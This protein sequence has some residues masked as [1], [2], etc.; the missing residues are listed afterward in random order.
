MKQ[1]SRI[2]IKA[3]MG[4]PPLGGFRRGENVTECYGGRSVPAKMLSNVVLAARA[5]IARMLTNV[6]FCTGPHE[7]TAAFPGS[8]FPSAP[9]ENMPDPGFAL[10]ETL[11]PAMR[12][13]LQPSVIWTEDCPF[14][15]ALRKADRGLSRSLNLSPRGEVGAILR[16]RVRD[17]CQREAKLARLRNSVNR[18]LI[19]HF[20]ESEG[21]SLSASRS[22]Q[23][24]SRSEGSLLK[25]DSDGAGVRPCI[26]ARS[27]RAT[28]SPTA[29]R[30]RRGESQPPP[31]SPPDARR[32]G[33]DPSLRSG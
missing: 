6:S 16:H 2:W 28:S 9:D 23:K 18:C 13:E 33:R 29:R 10:I 3:T 27:F 15:E 21:R 24:E 20:R 11:A 19:C 8:Q 4:I 17:R 31:A 30:C 12:L 26:D 7:K 25:A 32:T 5:A 1:R 14:S 22:P